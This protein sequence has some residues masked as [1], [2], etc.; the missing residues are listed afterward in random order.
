MQIFVEHWGGKICNFTLFLTLGGMNLDHDFFQVSKLS[1]DQKKG[2]PPK[3]EHF[4][5]RIQVETR[6][7]M[8]TEVEL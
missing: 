8:L 5:P 6:A 7:Q 1:E 2:L 4:F 3:T